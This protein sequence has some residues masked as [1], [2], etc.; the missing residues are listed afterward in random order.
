MESLLIWC[1]QMYHKYQGTPTARLC[2]HSVQVWGCLCQEMR[3]TTTC[4]FASCCVSGSYELFFNV[5]PSNLCPVQNVCQILIP[6]H[7]GAS[8]QLTVVLFHHFDS[9][10]SWCCQSPSLCTSFMRWPRLSAGNRVCLMVAA[11]D[12]AS[13]SWFLSRAAIELSIYGLNASS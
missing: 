13:S 10:S 1:S 11:G 4:V 8:V 12:H 7:N 9:C 3:Q 2:S 5:L 6:F